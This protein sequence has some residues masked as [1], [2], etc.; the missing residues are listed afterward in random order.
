MKRNPVGRR[1]FMKGI[2]QSAAVMSALPKDA[3]AMADASPGGRPGSAHA[4]GSTQS[5]KPGIRFGVIGI[6]HSHINSQ[7][8]AVL[9]GGGELVSLY[10][11]EDDLAADLVRLLLE[12]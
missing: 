9:R 12:A 4:G 8:N 7:V 1:T 6:N 11:K 5:A 2:A 10:A 3:F